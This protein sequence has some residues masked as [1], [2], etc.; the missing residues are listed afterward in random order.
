MKERICSVFMFLS[1]TTAPT[2]ALSSG[3]ETEPCTLRVA[4]SFGAKPTGAQARSRRAVIHPT[5][6]RVIQSSRFFGCGEG[7]IGSPRRSGLFPVLVGI[8][9]LFLD[10]TFF[11]FL[12]FVFFFGL[13]QFQRGG[14]NHF[15]S[16]AT[17]I[18]TDGVAFVHIFFIDVDIVLAC[19]TCD[20]LKSSRIL[21][22]YTIDARDCNCKVRAG[23]GAYLAACFAIRRR[24]VAGTIPFNRR[25]MK[26]WARWVNSCSLT[27]CTISRRV[28][29][30]PSNRVMM[31]A[32]KS[33]DWAASSSVRCATDSRRAMASWEAPAAPSA[34]GSARM[35]VFRRARKSPAL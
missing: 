9:L 23:R 26:S 12:V 8:L 18:A 28:T 15:E 4:L 27:V 34:G 13:F 20:H 11:I 32:K 14:P 16:G 5:N 24:V 31:C 25:Y 3:L 35:W 19:R 29:C 1:C 2:A 21:T 17:L 30:W 7:G 10:E 22:V 6:V 33:G